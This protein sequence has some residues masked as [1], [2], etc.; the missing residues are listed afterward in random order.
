[1]LSEIGNTKAKIQETKAEIKTFKTTMDW[2]DAI[3]IKLHDFASPEV[4]DYAM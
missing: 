1:M 3:M 2:M 4:H